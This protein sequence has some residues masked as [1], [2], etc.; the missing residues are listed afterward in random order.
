LIVAH[1]LPL[2]A[3][4]ELA[5]GPGDRAGFDILRASQL[6]RRLLTIAALI[7]A[8]DSETSHAE[9]GCVLECLAELETRHRDVFTDVVTD[10]VAAFLAAR[11]LRDVRRS[12]ESA[13]Q[14][15]LGY[16]GAVVTAAAIR[17]GLPCSLR[18]PVTAD[19]LMLPTLGLAMV[20]SDNGAGAVAVHDDGVELGGT[21]RIRFPDLAHDHPRWFPLRR[22]TAAAG[23]L[24]LSVTLDDVGPH[25][26]TYGFAG[27]GRLSQ[28]GLDAWRRQL[29]TAWELLVTAHRP[30]AEPMAAGLRA[31][32]PLRGGTRFGRSASVRQAFG[33]VA[34]TTPP[35]A[36]A[37][38]ETLVHEFQHAKLGALA[39]LVDLHD[40][41]D[42]RLFYS[43]WRDDPRPVDGLLQG[44]YA[45]LGVSDFWRVRMAA[46]DAGRDYARFQY[47]RAAG[48]VRRAVDTLDASGALT[49]LGN[50]F[51]AG[52]VS[53]MDRWAVP[54]D[55]SVD[56]VAEATIDDHW[57][58]WL[59]HNHRTDER[60]IERLTNEWLHG[61]PNPS[62]LP[63]RAVV[64]AAGPE[65]PA[66][67]RLRLIQL[68]AFDQ[69]RFKRLRT[70]PAALAALSTDATR[71]D[72][73]FAE[74]DLD[75]AI[76]EY[77]DRLARD[78]DDTLAWSGLASSGRRLGGPAGEGWAAYPDL[79]RA[80][81]RRLRRLGTP[82]TPMALAGWLGRAA[83]RP[84]RG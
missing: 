59:L 42:N 3:L 40:R 27:H 2:A 28:R 10:P 6:S 8:A 43:P 68:N 57:T 32:A 34:L 17:V 12:P 67:F 54:A 73:A 65:L 35:N 24:R 7:E 41:T 22:L 9:L 51:V 74:G 31:L 75:G 82:P 71:G 70:D 46:G 79:I 23:D 16:L 53:A 64:G 52:M 66:D 77:L 1:R 83:T 15:V 56:T 48:Q 19:G 45:Y 20:P 38:A 63:D 60:D 18:L 58:A 14:R 36:Q 30:Y 29:A 25:E 47:V 62:V 13:G 39:D 69:P 33:A 26:A 78:P 72:L 49:E 80:L 50:R 55:E 4:D 81:Y 37:F 44:A 61:A 11:T 84:L 21:V 5:A 76:R